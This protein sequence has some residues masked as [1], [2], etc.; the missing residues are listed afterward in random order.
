MTTLAKC[1]SKDPPRLQ[2]Y[3]K[4]IQQQLERDIIELSPLQPE[5]KVH[6]LPHNPVLTAAKS[7]K[8]RLVYHASSKAREGLPVA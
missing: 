1:L 6:Y 8:V 4:V 2:R 3:N 5:G 7:T